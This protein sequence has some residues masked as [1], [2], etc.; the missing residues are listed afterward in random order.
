MTKTTPYPPGILS[1][2][3]DSVTRKAKQAIETHAQVTSDLSKL[4]NLKSFFKMTE[5][6]DLVKIIAKRAKAMTRV[7]ELSKTFRMVHLDQTI[8]RK[9]TVERRF[10][11]PRDISVPFIFSAKLP[12]KTKTTYTVDIPVPEPR[13]G[14]RSR[15][16]DR[17]GRRRRPERFRVT[18]VTPLPPDGAVAALQEHGAKFHHTEVW[19]VPKDVEVKEVRER[20][21][22]P[23]VVGVII[24]PRK[25]RDPERFCFELFRWEQA[26]LEKPYFAHEAY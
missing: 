1:K 7:L 19:W 18:S 15:R 21:A 25:N 4:G 11:G 12:A 13:P 8:K 24:A 6:G 14:T 5:T 20:L 10:E 2:T 26:D 3:P 23:I 9:V 16:F 17:W 22:D